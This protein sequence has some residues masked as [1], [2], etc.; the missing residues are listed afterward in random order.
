MLVL[1]TREDWDA[2]KPK[3][4][5]MKDLKGPT[6]LHWNGTGMGWGKVGEE[7]RLAWVK[8]RLRIGQ[9]YH[10]KTRGYTDIA[11]SFAVDPWGMAAWEL[12]GL[13]VQPGATKGHNTKSHAI[14]VMTGL[15]DGP[16]TP[17]CLTMIDLLVDEIATAARA[18]NLLK[19]HRDVGRTNCPGDYLHGL[20]ALFNEDAF[21]AKE[22][23]F[24][25]L[26][27]KG[28]GEPVAMFVLGD[29][30]GIVDARGQVITKGASQLGDLR[31]AGLDQPI[32]DAEG[33]PSGKGYILV[34]ADGGVFTFGDAVYHGS[35][36]QALDG[37]MPVS[38][39]VS[40]EVEEG[41]YYMVAAD[42]GI[43][44]FGNL[45]WLGAFVDEVN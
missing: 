25:S 33:T 11:Y 16:V 41:G 24:Q 39:I 34:A 4:R 15:G 36:R 31:T 38:P 37:R 3:R 5:K 8:S 9:A 2:V 30:Y 1:K 28:M 19:G 13:D 44:T 35:L 40:V 21:E 20:L 10:M 6:Y 22:P 18:E 27:Q 17:E 29:G 14:Y 45:P 43:F 23:V 26:E 32:V 7:D 12:R 42:G